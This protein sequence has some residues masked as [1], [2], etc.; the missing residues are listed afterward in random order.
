MSRAERERGDRHGGDGDRGRDGRAPPPRGARDGGQA[1]RVA[2]GRD[3]LRRSSRS[4]R[5]GASPCRARAPASIAAGSSAPRS[6]AL[7]ARLLQVRED[8]GDVGAAP[9]RDGAGEALEQQAGQP[10]LVGAAVERL[11]ADL[12]GRD[13]VDRAHQ[14]AVGAPAVRRALRQAEVGQVA[15]LASLLAVEQHVARLD[16]AVDEPARVRR[17]QRVGD[18]GRDRDRPGGLERALAPQ[19]RLEVTARDV[20]HGDEQAAV[21]LARLVDRDHV[22][23]VEAGR[24]ARL[25]HTRALGGGAPARAA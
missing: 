19:Q 1:E 11:A 4:A 22:R 24:E 15:V 10:V 18:L 9:E 7:G 13:V 5:P 16:V 25:A 6:D 14:L 17:V 3:E 8:R 12:L 23:V 21:A 20:A 2:R